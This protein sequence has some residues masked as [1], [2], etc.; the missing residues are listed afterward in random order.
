MN[1]SRR[2][3]LAAC[4]ALP[5]AVG[6]GRAEANEPFPVFASDLEDVPYKFRK[7][8]VDYKTSE[9]PG[10]IVVDTKKRFLYFV[11]GKGRALRYG[12]GVGKE[13]F[14]WSGEA[15]VGRMAK[16]PKWTPTAEQ[17]QRISFYAKWKDGMPPGPRNPLGARAIYLYRD[18]KD[19]LYRIHGSSEPSTIGKRVSSGC[20]RMVDT[21]VIDLYK[22]VKVGTRVVVFDH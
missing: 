12:I 19:L 6:F 14:T 3:F 18:G 22:R 7:Q 16:W 21:E 2:S 11:L 4:L 17:I 15:K 5:A 8:E 10:T 9:A 13:G 20:L 1:T